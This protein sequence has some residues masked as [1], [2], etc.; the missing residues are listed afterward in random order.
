M[1]N[2]LSDTN[3]NLLLSMQNR[4]TMFNPITGKECKGNSI[5]GQTAKQCYQGHIDSFGFN[6]ANNSIGVEGAAA[7]AEGLPGLTT[8]NVRGN[9]IVAEG[10]AAIAKG[11]SGLTTLNRIF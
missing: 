9:S 3:N 2:Q 4:T 5:Y 11:L 6:A 8:P 7:I 10:A 1:E